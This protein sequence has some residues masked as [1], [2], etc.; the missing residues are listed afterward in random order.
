MVA[1]ES[2]WL[3]FAAPVHGPVK[4]GLARDGL[5]PA[6]RLLLVDQPGA[7]ICVD[8]HL[9]AGESIEG[10]TRRH[11]GGAHGAVRNHQ[12]LNGD[13]GQEKH[14]ADHVVAAHHKL[15]EGLDHLAGSR[16][17]LRTVQQDA[18]AGSNVQG[19]PEESQQQQQGGKDA[20]FDC[21]ANLHGREK[22]DDRGGHR[23]RQQEV[24]RGSRQR[25]QHDEDHADRRQRQHVLAHPLPE[26]Q[27]GQ[28]SCRQS[29]GTHRVPPPGGVGAEPGR[30]PRAAA[31]A[32]VA[33]SRARRS[34]SSASTR[35]R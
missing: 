5:P 15:P 33:A 17:A 8:G 14:E 24:Q 26:R 35:W 22:D 23:K 7:H 31:C 21:P 6:P 18:A 13:Q 16:G 2:R 12:E 19:Q 34:R 29:G 4:L 9:L 3:N 11:F 1:S 27:N 20:E 28:C 32:R 25:H 10:E 30:A